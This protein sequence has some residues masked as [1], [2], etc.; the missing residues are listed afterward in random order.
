[1]S[2]FV[3]TAVALAEGATV[4]VADQEGRFGTVLSLTDGDLATR[5]LGEALVQWDRGNV[6]GYRC[7][8]FDARLRVVRVIR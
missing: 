2:A 7:D 5:T 1:M 6:T 4:R 3:D 8:R